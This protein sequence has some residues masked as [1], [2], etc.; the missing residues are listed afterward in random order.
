MT[1]DKNENQ[2]RELKFGTSM[3]FNVYINIQVNF[4]SYK[5]SSDVNSWWQLITVNKNENQPRELK[6]GSCIN[7]SV[8]I[9][10]LV[11]FFSYEL[12]SAVNSCR[13]LIKMKII[14]ECWNLAHPSTL[15]STWKFQLIFFH[16]SPHQLSTADISW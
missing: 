11:K 4:L 13:Q 15:V 2:P 12:S 9:N 3:N 14:L 5:L 1:A 16:I 7:F 8:Y 6:F 10:I